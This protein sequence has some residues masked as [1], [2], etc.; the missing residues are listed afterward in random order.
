M[1]KNRKRYNQVIII[2]SSDLVGLW[3]LTPLSTLYF[4][5]IVVVSFIGGGNWSSRRKSLTDF[6]T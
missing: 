4:S 6:I 5:M 2:F 3:C 1:M